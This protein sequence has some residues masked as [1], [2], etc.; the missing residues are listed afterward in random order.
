M[1]FL[2]QEKYYMKKKQNNVIELV[3]KWVRIHNFR[4]D[5]LSILYSIY[6]LNSSFLDSK[7]FISIFGISLSFKPSILNS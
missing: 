4:I 2:K 3:K 6:L 7:N 1:K 5:F